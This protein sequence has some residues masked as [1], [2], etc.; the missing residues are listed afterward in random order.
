MKGLIKENSTCIIVGEMSQDAEKIKRLVAFKKKLEKRVED[1]ESE[2]KELQTMLEAVNSILL[3]KGFKRAELP[4]APAEVEA[5]PPKEEV[6]VE[7]VPLIEYESVTPL[8]TADGELL[9]N[10]YTSG[11]MVRVVPVE[12]KNFNVNTPPFTPF[13]VERIF[14]KMQ[15]KDNELSRTGQLPP[16]RVFSYNIVRE[17]DTIR[18]IV[19]EHVD[20]DRLRELKSSIRWTLEKMYEKMKSQG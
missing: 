6:P 1:L 12:G 14:S 4:K 3:E 7:K 11:D 10:L 19:I 17:G 2:L 13:L 18:E 9:A 8:K 15:E 5:L 16:E 20:Q